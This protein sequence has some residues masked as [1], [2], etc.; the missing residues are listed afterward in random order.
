MWW[1][2]LKSG[3]QHKSCAV[4][5]RRPSALSGPPFFHWSSARLGPGLFR[6]FCSL[7]LSGLQ[8]G[9]QGGR[10]SCL[11]GWLGLGCVSSASAQARSAESCEIAPEEDIDGQQED[12]ID[13]ADMSPERL[14]LNAGQLLL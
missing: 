8:F 11:C 14:L 5:L 3:G 9:Q 13:V 10:K 12:S 7:S 4:A 2:E 1:K 6:C